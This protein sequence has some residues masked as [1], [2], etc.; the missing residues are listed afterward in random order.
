MNRRELKA[1]MKAQRRALEASQRALRARVAQLP[2]VKAA[3][4]RRRNRRL[5][6]LTVLL[7]LLCFIRCDCEPG[8]APVAEVTDAGVL[9][10]EKPVVK[11]KPAAPKPKSPLN[12]KV[13]LG[14]RDGFGSNQR[15]TPDWLD[16]F[17]LQ[18]A[19]RSPRLSAC[20]EGTERP[21][22]LRWVAAVNPESGAVSDQTLDPV[23]SALELTKEQR[24]CLTQVLSTPPFKKLAAVE[25]QALP[26]RVSM[27]IEF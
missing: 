9:V 11:P 10:V 5:A 25:G 22:A 27:V 23:G 14:P 3:A 17:R 15:S 8:P 12:A 6:L 2:Q 16:A 20:F 4:R 26:D 18:V 24:K 13:S 21:G 1:A 19:A 7:L